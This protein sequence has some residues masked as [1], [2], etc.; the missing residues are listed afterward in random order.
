MQCSLGGGR[1]APSD[2][3]CCDC[4]CSSS[5]KAMER[6]KPLGA[7]TEKHLTAL[8]ERRAKAM[9]CVLGAA[10]AAAEMALVKL[11]RVAARRMDCLYVG[12]AN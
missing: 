12:V 10:D 4:C 1:F 11:A 8:A 6:E 3:Y 5:H 2:A 7:A 9:D